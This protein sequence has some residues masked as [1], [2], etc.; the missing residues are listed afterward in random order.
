MTNLNQQQEDDT[1]TNRSTE[2]IA[3][4]SSS[5]VE[6]KEEENKEKDEDEYDDDT[7]MNTA[8]VIAPQ[9]QPILCLGDDEDEDDD[10][11]TGKPRRQMLGYAAYHGPKFIPAEIK[12]NVEHFLASNPMPGFVQ[13]FFG[14]V[15][16]GRDDVSGYQ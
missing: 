8:D 13:K 1:A 16:L 5:V 6:E 4:T 12:D 11:Y 2:D 7:N 3:S 15:F 10:G 9:Y 14:T